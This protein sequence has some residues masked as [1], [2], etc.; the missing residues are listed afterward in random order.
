MADMI[1]KA[2]PDFFLLIL[3]QNPRRTASLAQEHDSCTASGESN[4]TFI[5]ARG[6]SEDFFCPI[7][8]T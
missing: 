5:Q 7:E 4:R 1:V 6:R 2:H 8:G 3:Q